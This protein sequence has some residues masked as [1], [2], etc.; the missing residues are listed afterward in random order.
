MCLAHYTAWTPRI[1]WT[2]PLKSILNKSAR[3][4]LSEQRTRWS[5]HFLPGENKKQKT[6]LSLASRGCYKLLSFVHVWA[7]QWDTPAAAVQ[8]RALSLVQLLPWSNNIPKESQSICLERKCERT[9]FLLAITANGRP[10]SLKQAPGTRIQAKS[11]MYWF[12]KPWWSPL[13]HTST[14]AKSGTLRCNASIFGH[15]PLNYNP[16]LRSWHPIKLYVARVFK[17]GCLQVFQTRLQPILNENLINLD[18]EIWLTSKVLGCVCLVFLS[19]D[20]LFICG[21]WST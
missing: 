12:K 18:E 11:S 4:I 13:P 2:N 19:S 9:F 8:S 17:G 21:L 7:K 16:K 10:K 1:N 3:L 6:F 20:V 5:V 14:T 15:A